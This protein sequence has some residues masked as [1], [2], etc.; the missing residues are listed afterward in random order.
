M[1][2]RIKFQ[3]GQFQ[4]GGRCVREGMLCVAQHFVVPTESSNFVANDDADD[5]ALEWVVGLTEVNRMRL[6]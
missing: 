6:C 2:T 3:K 1:S 5:A 4:M